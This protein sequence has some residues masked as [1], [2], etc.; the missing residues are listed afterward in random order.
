V[1]EGHHSQSKLAIGGITM[2]DVEAG[3][4]RVLVYR[5]GARVTRVGKTELLAGEHTIRIGGISEYAQQDSF[6][7][8]GRGKAVLRGMDVKRMRQVH[9]PEGDTGELEK[10]L[11]K[12]QMK[13]DGIRDKLAVQ[14]ARL[15]SLN[16]ISSQFA[17]EFGKWYAAGETKIDGLTELDTK[18]EEMIRSAK[19]S[20]RQ[21][22]EEAKDVEAEIAMLTL[23]I[24]QVLGTR[25]VETLTEAHVK[26]EVR[27]PSAIELELTYQVDY[28]GWEPTYDVDIDDGKTTVKRIAMIHNHTLEAW[29][30]VGLQVSTASA[31]RVEAVTPNPY[32]IDVYRPRPVPAPKASRAKDAGRRVSLIDDGLLMA[33]EAMGEAQMDE[34][35]ATAS[36]NLSGTTVY[37]VPGEVTIEA[38]DEPHPVTLT[39]EDF[40][41][42]R[43]Y[44]W[45]A[46]DMPEVVAQDEITNGDSVLLPGDV[47]VY[48][49]G[50][51][52]GETRLDL[53]APREEFRLGTRAAYD[54][55]AEKKLVEKETDKAGI[56]RGKRKRAYK[57]QL[58]LTS[59]SKED[60]EIRVYDTIPHSHSERI[61]VELK[62][63][64]HPFK[65][66]ELGVIEWEL[67]IP[68]G[69][70]ILITYEFE[71]EWER[72]VIIRPPLP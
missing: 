70:K 18:S 17:D 43:L 51:F 24:Q 59:F 62:Q 25:S 55:K 66:M 12:L 6:R 52:V 29:E 16:A 37:E 63:S 7:V 48:A 8:K 5:N 44:Y 47:K 22:Q 58:E 46:V 61:A 54:V 19:K 33:A 71:V 39:L 28:A 64:S 26:L 3:I 53:I 36:E 20:I 56:T 14:E 27:E 72:D 11:K 38:T 41:S 21:M 42:R 57:Y 35:Y 9:D 31:R 1:G 30:E 32:Y 50:D 69:E 10:K 23:N 45:N 60:I 13:K 34:T 65:R 40:H 15:S 49:A 4:T 68:A 2:K 67:E